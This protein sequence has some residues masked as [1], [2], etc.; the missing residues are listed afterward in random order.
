MNAF[1]STY[2][3]DFTLSDELV[4]TLPGSS[5]TF[6]TGTASGYAYI[7]VDIPGNYAAEY[8]AAIAPL[9]T[10][11]GYTKKTDTSGSEYYANA[12]DH[13]VSFNYYASGDYTEVLFFE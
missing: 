12:A 2:G 9:L 13:Q 4:A 3:L 8:E 6:N 10:A 11:A 7:Y 5:F 1:L